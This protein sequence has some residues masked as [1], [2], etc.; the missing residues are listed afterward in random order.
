MARADH[1]RGNRVVE[2]LGVVLVVVHHLLL[3]RHAHAALGA[4]R[5]A[6]H[7]H[8]G[9]RLVLR[10]APS[11]AGRRSGERRKLLDVELQKKP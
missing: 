8:A 6:R 7:F 3:Q 11:F 9:A 5:A 2:H 10:P 1:R 4:L